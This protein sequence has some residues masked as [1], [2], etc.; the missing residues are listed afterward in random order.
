MKLPAVA[1][2]V[3]AGTLSPIELVDQALDAADRFR[4]LNALAEVHADE[5][6]KLAAQRAAEAASGRVRGALHGSAHQD[7]VVDGFACLLAL[8][9]RYRRWQREA[10]PFRRL[11]MPATAA[12]TKW[13]DRARIRADN[14][15]WGLPIRTTRAAAGWVVGGSAVAVAVGIG[16]P[17]WTRHRCSLRIP[18]SLCG[19][20]TIKPCTRGTDGRSGAPP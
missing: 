12:T 3:R 18:A 10:P 14:R 5:A 6:R 20:A 8:E 11:R 1:A 16:L 19:V 17:R 15:D 7:V 9:R 13:T 2:G 4:H